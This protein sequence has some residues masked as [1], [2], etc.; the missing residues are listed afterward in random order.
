MQHIPYSNRGYFTGGKNVVIVVQAIAR[1]PPWL[2]L[3]RRAQ[4]FACSLN[5]RL[6]L[7]SGSVIVPQ[8]P[9]RRPKHLCLTTGSRPLASLAGTAF[10]SPLTKRYEPNSK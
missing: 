9:T 10:R 1:L 6:N 2:A 3:K 4:V 8:L 7:R 5:R